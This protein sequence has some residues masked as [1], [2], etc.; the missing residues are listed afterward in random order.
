LTIHLVPLERM[1]VDRTHGHQD[2]PYLARR[3]PLAEQPVD[4][5]LQVAAAYIGEPEPSEV[6]NHVVAKISGVAAQHRRLVSLP[7]AAE[8][9][10]RIGCRALKP[11]LRRLAQCPPSGRREPAALLCA[12]RVHAP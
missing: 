5:R 1:P 11:G 6:W 7:G 10:G 12:E 9:H 4:E 2:V 8:D 3:E